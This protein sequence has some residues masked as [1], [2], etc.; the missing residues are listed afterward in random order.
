M[1]ARKCGGP[2]YFSYWNNAQYHKHIYE[3]CRIYA[4]VVV[5]HDERLQ[6]IFWGSVAR[7]PDGIDEYFALMQRYHGNSGAF[8]ALTV[9]DG[10]REACDLAPEYPLIAPEIRKCIGHHRAFSAQL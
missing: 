2:E 5:L 6:D 10:K 4:G 1:G 7:R 9:I 8:A 3:L